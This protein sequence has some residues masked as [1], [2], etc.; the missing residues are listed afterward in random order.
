MPL[1]RVRGQF[2]DVLADDADAAVLASRVFWAAS[3][4][5]RHLCGC[6]RGRLPVRDTKTRTTTHQN[7]N[8]P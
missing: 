3:C 8:K 1:D 2:S 5:Y 6:L 4:T 7:R